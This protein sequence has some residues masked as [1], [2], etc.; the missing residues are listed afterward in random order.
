[1]EVEHVQK[2]EEKKLPT[3]VDYKSIEGLSLEA[4]E[5]LNKVRPE[6]IGQAGRISG[7]S[8]SDVSVLVIWLSKQRNTSQK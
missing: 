4:I 2:L 5:K 7:V 3:D 1:M 6:N 8:P